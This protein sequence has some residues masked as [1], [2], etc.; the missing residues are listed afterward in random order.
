VSVVGAFGRVTAQSTF[1][2]V[3]IGASA[4]AFRGLAA[5]TSTMAILGSIPGNPTNAYRWDYL[6][7]TL[8]P[9][10]MPAGATSLSLPTGNSTISAD[11]GVI[12]GGATF[13]V[14]TGPYWW[15]ASG[16]AHAVATLPTAIFTQANC[17]NGSGTLLGGFAN[18]PLSVRH[19]FVYSMADGA[20]YDLHNLFSA[21]G[22]LPT[23]WT[24]TATQ[25]ISNDG[26]RFFC[27][28]TA[29][30]GSTRTMVLD[31]DFRVPAPGAG[32]V[33]GM[34]GVVGMGRRRRAN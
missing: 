9:L 28:A 30:D 29:P 27:L 14:P 25:S 23:G 2:A 13:G 31:G 17:V 19:A 22:L 26:S 16:T 24:L 20:A 1:T 34:A 33:L 7:S 6:A 4:G 8:S 11:G 18:F 5:N 10:N 21:A 3:N 15:D 32:A 12:V